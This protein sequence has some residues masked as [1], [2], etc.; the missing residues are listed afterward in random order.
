MDDSPWARKNTAGR[1][2]DK[3]CDGK[4][5]DSKR[6]NGIFFPPRSNLAER[7]LIKFLVC[8]DSSRWHYNGVYSGT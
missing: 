1:Y 8:E 5:N 2:F 4:Q 7:Y 3:A 6:V